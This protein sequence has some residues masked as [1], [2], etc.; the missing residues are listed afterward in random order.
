MDGWMDGWMDGRIHFPQKD[1]DFNNSLRV[2]HIAF[3]CFLTE[4]DLHEHH[5]IRIS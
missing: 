1:E 2:R 3:C 5:V 4:V